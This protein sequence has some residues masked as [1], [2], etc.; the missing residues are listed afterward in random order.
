MRNATTL[1]SVVLLVAASA[2]HA[3][4]HLQASEVE[5]VRYLIVIEKTKSGFSA[6]SPDLAGCVAAARTRPS[7][8]RE[9]R[10]AIQFHLEG[11]RAEGRRVPTPKSYSAYVEIPA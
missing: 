8:E 10:E 4:Q 3:Q 5:A 11:L 9:M 6:Y 2:G 7:V 1:F